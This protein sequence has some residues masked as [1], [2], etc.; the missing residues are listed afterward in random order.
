MIEHTLKKKIN[1]NRKRQREINE[2]T[3]REKDTQKDT[4]TTQEKQ[5]TQIQTKKRARKIEDSAH[6][7]I[8]TI[9]IYNTI[10]DLIQLIVGRR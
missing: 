1:D 10:H 4:E 2:T 6:M 7:R 5:I 9:T 3:H 8:I